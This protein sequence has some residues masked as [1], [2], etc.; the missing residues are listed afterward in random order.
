YFGLSDHGAEGTFLRGDIAVWRDGSAERE[1]P[2]SQWLHLPGRHNVANALAATVAALAGGATWEQVQRGIESYQALPHRL[3]FVGEVAGRKFY[4]D[5]LATTPESAIVG[6]DAFVEP[7]ILLAGG[8]DK[9][10]DLSEMAG[11]IARRAK[12]V[13]LMGQTG[14]VLERLLQQSL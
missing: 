7:V 4:N 1:F 10:V 3:Q 14:P 2:L 12:A 9:Q 8:Y 6:L 5:S 13:A 11:H